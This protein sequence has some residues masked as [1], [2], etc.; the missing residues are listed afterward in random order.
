M[1]KVCVIYGGPRK[2][3][4]YGAV[5]IVK[6]ELA[7]RGDEMCIRDSSWMPGG[8]MIRQLSVR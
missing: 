4:T 8:G 3:N 6:E 1:K 7:R 5:Q 2:K